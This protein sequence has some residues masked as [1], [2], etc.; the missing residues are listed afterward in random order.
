MTDTM[1]L[2]S[3]D[4]HSHM[5]DTMSLQSHDPSFPQELPR[6][7]LPDGRGRVG[8]EESAEAV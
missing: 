5:T 6:V 4:R 1:S 2:W 7:L 8:A 3:H